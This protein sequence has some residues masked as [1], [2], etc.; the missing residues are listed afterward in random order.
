MPSGTEVP[1]KLRRDVIAQ[2]HRQ[3]GRECQRRA[4]PFFPSSARRYPRQEVLPI[5]SPKDHANIAQYGL[6][7]RPA[8]GSPQY[9]DWRKLVSTT[10][11]DP[12]LQQTIMTHG[13]ALNLSAGPSALTNGLTLAAASSTNWSGYAVSAAAGTFNVNNNLIHARWVVPIAQQAFG[14]C[15]GTWWDSSQWLGFDGSGSKDVLQAGT[16]ADAYC[17]GG[18]TT[19]EYSF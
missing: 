8:I 19:P 1:R 4:D 3:R 2:H 9:E 10:R 14:S 13:P 7:P 5:H 11:I 6:P 12:V 17:A 16:E 18:A 15:D